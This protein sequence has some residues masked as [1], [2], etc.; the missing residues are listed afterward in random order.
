MM[1]GHLTEP[2][3]IEYQ[4]AVTVD[5]VLPPIKPASVVSLDYDVQQPLTSRKRTKDS[6]SPRDYQRIHRVAT[7]AKDMKIGLARQRE[8]ATFLSAAQAIEA[9]GL[10]IAGKMEDVAGKVQKRWEHIDEYAGRVDQQTGVLSKVETF[11]HDKVAKIAEFEELLSEYRSTLLEDID[12]EDSYRT[13]TQRYQ[14]YLH[15][16]HDLRSRWHEIDAPV[17]PETLD[18]DKYGPE[19]SPEKIREQ[20]GPEIDRY[21]LPIPK[22]VQTP[23]NPRNPTMPELTVP[24]PASDFQHR[25]VKMQD[26][27]SRTLADLDAEIFRKAGIRARI[28]RNLPYVGHYFDRGPKLAELRQTRRNLV[29]HIMDRTNRAANDNA[30]DQEAFKGW[31]RTDNQHAAA[32]VEALSTHA[33]TLQGT[34]EQLKETERRLDR[35]WQYLEGRFVD[36]NAANRMLEARRVRI[37]NGMMTYEEW[38]KLEAQTLQIED[39][40]PKATLLEEPEIIEPDTTQRGADFEEEQDMGNDER[41]SFKRD[42]D[43][44]PEPG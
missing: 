39:Q 34:N 22:V 21:A 1:I 30:R 44:G 3:Q 28:L 35:R 27:R 43:D 26:G 41:I 15:F 20:I 5:F 36:L 33:R 4:P 11:L 23:Q 31:V 32:Y 19:V 2:P 24:H 14:A 10:D 25:A 38:D 12:Y 9:E 18:A 42:N 17:R 7:V 6:S 29:V 8:E 37:Y 13:S 40:R 16:I